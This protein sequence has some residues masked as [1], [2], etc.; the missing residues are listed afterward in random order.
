MQ[1]MIEYKSEIKMPDISQSK[2]IIKSHKYTL[3]KMVFIITPVYRDNG[4][5]AKEILTKLMCEEVKKN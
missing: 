2:D 5:N 3:D 1:N 4:K